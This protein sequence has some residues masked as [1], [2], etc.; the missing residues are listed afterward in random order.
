TLLFLS[1]NP[2]AAIVKFGFWMIVATACFA[3]LAMYFMACKDVLE[4]GQPL[5]ILFTNPHYRYVELSAY[6]NLH[7]S[8]LSV[9]LMSAI[10][11]IVI[12][13]GQ[14]SSPAGKIAY[15][16]LIAYLLFLLFM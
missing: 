13:F 6:I 7:P 1:G 12:N 8:Y 4:A 10:I 2:R 16:C 11:V 14:G 15:S 3:G 9:L 5:S